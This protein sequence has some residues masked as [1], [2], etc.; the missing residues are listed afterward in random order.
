MAARFLAR[1]GRRID[2][3]STAVGQVDG[4]TDSGVKIRN[5]DISQ[6]MRHAGR[7]LE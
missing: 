7:N 1:A 5:L 2:L 6:L 3:S 4:R